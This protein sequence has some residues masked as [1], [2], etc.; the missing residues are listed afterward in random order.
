M[1]LLMCWRKVY[2]RPNVELVLGQQLTGIEPAMGGDA[3]LTLNRNWLGGPTLCVRGTSWR[4]AARFT[5]NTIE[6][7]TGDDG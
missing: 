2:S 6:S 7:S 4:H 3:D 5:D 1:C